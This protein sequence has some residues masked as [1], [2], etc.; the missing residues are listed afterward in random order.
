MGVRTF[1][2]GFRLSV[3]D[4]VVLIVGGVGA[5][6]MMSLD[7]WTGI[8]IL[9]VELH[10]FLFCNVLRMARRLELIWAGSFVALVVA[11]TLFEVIAW[12]AVFAISAVVTVILTLIEIRRPLYHGVAWRK[13]NPRLLDRWNSVEDG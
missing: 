1:Q 2:P 8:A 10:F 7:R 12:P 11:R 13:F 5:W 3:L 4:V 6:S 9:F